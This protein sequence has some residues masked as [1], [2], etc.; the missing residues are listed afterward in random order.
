M[1]KKVIAVAVFTLGAT[2]AF[3]APQQEGARQGGQWGGHRGHHRHH[4]NGAAKLAEKL[5][6]S[7]AQKQQIKDIRKA[8][9]EENKAFFDNMRAT[10]QQFREAR[11]AND[12]AKLDA[13]KQSMQSQREQMKQIREAEM[14][15]VLAVFTP[16]QR[17][18]FEAMKAERQARRSERK[19]NG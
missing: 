18:Q 14:T 17:A 5:N 13:L 16:E 3:A 11:K 10:R 6:L 15:K 2:L 12:A 1:K 19:Q 7:E 4:K 9:R 8:S